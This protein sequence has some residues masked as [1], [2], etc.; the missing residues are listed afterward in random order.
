MPDR[1]VGLWLIGAFGGVGTTTAV[2]LA[3][4][5][6]KLSPPVGLV[7]ALPDFAGLDFDPAEAFLVGGHD[8]RQTTFSQTA[9]EL[10]ERSHI[11]SH[12]LLVG[13]GPTLE[14]WSKNVRAGVLY[15]ANA[16]IGAMADRPDVRESS[17]PKMAIEQIQ[18]DLRDF[19]SRHNLSQI[20]VVNVASTEPVFALTAEHQTLAKLRTAL[21]ENPAVLPT[22]SLYAYA[23]LDAGYSYVNFTPNRGATMPAMEELAR[24]KGVPTAGQ[25]AKTG[26]TLMKAVL[27]PL[28]AK[29]NLK[30]LSW[31][32]HNILG[33]RDGQ[34]LSDP[35]NKASKVKSKDVL[36][37]E[38]LGYK[39]QT[40]V[41]I[42]Y[43]PSLDDWKTAWDH[44]HYEG[45]LGTKM[46]L[47]FTWQGCDS[48][49]A[50]PL[51]IDLARLTLR[52]HR[53]GESG[54]LPA[55][56]SF[57]KSPVGV[58]DHDFTRQF[59]MLEEYLAIDEHR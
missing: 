48:I 32:G 29:R 46:T 8:I 11:F 50:A 15:R 54:N 44:I 18:S 23:A 17:S 4:L 37:A 25:D 33:N 6:Q 3:A 1:R 41:S 30:V 27:A 42:E 16:T 57:F 34:V 40:L 36:V 43:V 31:V 47:Q 9:A 14:A 52:A 49:L 10:L 38:L 21:A 59:G 2:G 24:A 5:A 13:V 20:V 45:F 22:S 28:F 7:T 51:A 58:D 56:A 53:H 19:Q 55:L 39:P 35:E 26:E 12:A